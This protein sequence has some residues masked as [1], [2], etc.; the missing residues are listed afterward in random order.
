M[1][2]ERT[3]DLGNTKRNSEERRAECR[4]R[5]KVGMPSQSEQLHHVT[6]NGHTFALLH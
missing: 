2:A 5:K 3:G 1:A 6:L 4:A